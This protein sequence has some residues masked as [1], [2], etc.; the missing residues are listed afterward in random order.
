MEPWRYSSQGL[1]IGLRVTPPGGGDGIDGIEMLS[2]D[3][4]W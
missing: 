3:G 1:S 2:M 4:R